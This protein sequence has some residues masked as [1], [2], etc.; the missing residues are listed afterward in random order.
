MAYAWIITKDHADVG[1]DDETVVGRTGPGTISE[2]HAA[3]LSAGKG[4]LFSLWDDD[5]E[6]YFEGRLITDDDE[7]EEEALYSPLRDYGAAWGAVRIKYRGH[8]DWEIG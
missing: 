5:G 6:R 8:P 2:E 7:P 3:A 1:G 4:H